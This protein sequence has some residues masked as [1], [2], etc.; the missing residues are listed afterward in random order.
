MCRALAPADVA[1]LDLV[2]ETAASPAW[3]RDLALRAGDLLLVNNY[4]VLHRHGGSA[5]T[6]ALEPLRLWITL[7][8][9]RALPA[10]FT[11]PTPAYGETGGRGGVAPRDVVDP[12]HCRPA[13]ADT[14]S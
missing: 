2:D 11:W 7:R 4:E 6:A 9:G 12:T 1:L 8:H 13:Q 5:G 3:R 10:A 14:R